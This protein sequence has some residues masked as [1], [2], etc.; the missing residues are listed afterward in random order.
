MM[1]SENL[2]TRI[3]ENGAL[4]RRTWALKALK[5]RTVILDS[6]RGC[7][8]NFEWL[9]SF[10]AEEQG[11]CGVWEVFGDFGWFLECLGSFTTYLQLVFKTEG[12][13]CNF[14]KHAWTMG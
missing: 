11:S 5:G 10:G 1:K 14:C 7:L 9:E 3:T 6:S 4:D 2:G 13:F 12:S 8:W